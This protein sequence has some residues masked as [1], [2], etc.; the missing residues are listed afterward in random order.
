M[1]REYEILTFLY[2]KLA[3]LKK[4]GWT[5]P[6]SVVATNPDDEHVFAMEYHC[7]ERKVTTDDMAKVLPDAKYPT[8]ITITDATGGHCWVEVAEDLTVQ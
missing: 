6:F 7:D 4:A 8:G 2:I 1:T 5:P 3:A